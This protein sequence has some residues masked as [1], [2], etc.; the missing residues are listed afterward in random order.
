MRLAAQ[1]AYP[2]PAIDARVAGIDVL[3][4]RWRVL[5]A[6][7]GAAFAFSEAI[8]GAPAVFARSLPQAQAGGPR[9]GGKRV[10]MPD[11]TAVGEIE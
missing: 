9:R 11:D 6:A 8:M 2:Y 1:V 4:V 10:L 3:G 7:V 5:D